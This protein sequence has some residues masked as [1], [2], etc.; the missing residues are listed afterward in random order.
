MKTKKQLTEEHNKRILK[1]REQFL[2]I[3]NEQLEIDGVEVM[4]PWWENKQEK[5]NEEDSERDQRSNEQNE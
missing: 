2:A 1:I 3:F 4:S 5:S